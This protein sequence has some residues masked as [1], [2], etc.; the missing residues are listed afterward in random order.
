MD[1][2][3]SVRTV[4][5]LA[6]RK[7]IVLGESGVMC[8]GRIDRLDPVSTKN[9]S[10]FGEGRYEQEGKLENDEE[11]A[12][13]RKGRLGSRLFGMPSFSVAKREGIISFLEGH[14]FQFCLRMCILECKSVLDRGSERDKCTYL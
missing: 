11:E 13:I 5:P 9:W 2:E 7:E 12:D 10:V 1:F 8:F 6:A 14:C 3:P 4:E